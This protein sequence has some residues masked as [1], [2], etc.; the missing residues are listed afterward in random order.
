MKCKGKKDRDVK[1]TIDNNQNTSEKKEDKI[2][3][4]HEANALFCGDLLNF[5]FLFLC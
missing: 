3:D 5:C 1:K 4:E 2:E